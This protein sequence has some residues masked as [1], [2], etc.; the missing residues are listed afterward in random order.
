MAKMKKF[1]R[2]F[3]KIITTVLFLSYLLLTA[4]PAYLWAKTTWVRQQPPERLVQILDQSLKENDPEFLT[5]WISMR[6]RAERD[7]IMKALEPHAGDIGS[8]NFLI[9]SMWMKSEDRKTDALFWRQYARYRLR[10]DALRCGSPGAVDSVAQLLDAFPDR[11][12]QKM[13]DEDK[14][15]LRQS[16]KQVLDFDAKHPALN[17]PASICENI[18]SLQRGNFVPVGREKW[19]AIR[20]TLRIVTEEALKEMEKRK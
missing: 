10:L 12:L 6:P 17:D 1:A 4:K 20:H 18:N 15:L 9:Y 19:A 13:L 14:N 2:L 5:E 11:E 8:T 3:L 7:S 16:L